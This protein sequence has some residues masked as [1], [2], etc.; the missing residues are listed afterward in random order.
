MAVSKVRLGNPNLVSPG[1]IGG[2]ILSQDPLV[3]WS[4]A[5]GGKG[6]GGGGGSKNITPLGL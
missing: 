5:K 6:G 3:S 2:H 1:L 4:L